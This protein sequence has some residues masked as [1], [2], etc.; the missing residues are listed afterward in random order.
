M[1]ELEFSHNP[2]YRYDITNFVKM[3]EILKKGKLLSEWH[4]GRI[5]N[6]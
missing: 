2:N 3:Q 5:Q 4:R 1:Q 6:N